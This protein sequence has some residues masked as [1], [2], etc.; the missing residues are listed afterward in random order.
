MY[1]LGDHFKIA[2]DAILANPEC[3]Y[4]G[5]K[6]RITVLTERL[7][8][9]EYSEQGIFEDRPSQLV[10]NRNFPSPKFMVKEDGKYIEIKTSYFTL[11]YTKNKPFAGPT[12]DRGKNLRIE[13]NGTERSWHYMHPEVRNYGAPYKTLGEK[14]KVKGLYSIEGFASINDSYTKLFEESGELVDRTIKETDLYV[15]VYIKDFDKALQDYFKLTGNPSLIPRFA[16]GNWWNKNEYYNDL[17]LKD[18][19]T[20]FTSNEIPLSVLLLDKDWHKRV[21]EGKKHL[22]TG[23]TFNEE[24]FANPG[25]MVNYLHSKGIRVGLTL[26]P[27]EGIY[28]IE[29]NFE[30]MK[31]YLEVNDKGIIPFNILSSKFIDVYLKLII[32][33]LDNFGIDFYKVDSE[34]L[35]KKEEMFALRHYQFN[36]MKRNYQHRPMMLAYNSNIAPHRYTALYSGK[37]IVSWDT[38]KEI[39]IFNSEAANNGVSYW[40][41]DIGGYYKG[42]EDPELFIRFVELGVFSSIMKLGADQGKYYKREPWKWNINTNSI[43]TKYMRLRHKLIPYLY[44]EAY[45]YT[46]EGMPIIRPLYYNFPEM[47]D[48]D[49]FRNEYYFGGEMFVAPIIHKKDPVMNRVIHKFYIPEGTWYD[50]TTGKKFPGGRSYI[51]FFR[52]EDYPVFARA[53]AI[54]PMTNIDRL[55]NINDTNPPKDLEVDIYPG[56]SN[57]YRLYEDD[58]VS[59]LYKKGYYLLSTIDYNYLP[60]NYTV[61]FR[62]IEGKSGIVPEKRNYKIRFKNTK[63]ADDVV[64]YFNNTP[65]PH[66][67]YLDGT[68]FIVEVKEVNTIGQLTINCKGKD[69]EIDAVRVINEDIENILTDLEIET[70]LKE[71]IDSILFSDLPVNKRKIALTKLRKKKL[72]SKYIRL[73]KNLL[74][75]IDQV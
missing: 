39:P 62:A 26:D 60:N 40:C 30:E 3:V 5:S 41:H 72:D 64:A 32:H 53:G 31:K 38:L 50:T 34:D 66:E 22:Q 13:V 73:F 27:S 20:K 65:V 59:S 68:D 37:T 6:Y 49:A 51:S 7:V 21:D 10:L 28:P 23:F 43:V 42:T 75:Y 12:I 15:F 24:L 56:R 8:R 70:E 52:D 1:N 67:A 4:Q 33:N 55:M 16:L 14:D 57:T 2:K 47:Y 9:L 29:N 11:Y 58:G 18:L 46:E 45:K 71:D 36:D 61:I 17:Q 35:K 69:I 48:D 74:N 19:I 63:K 54:I 44:S 25:V